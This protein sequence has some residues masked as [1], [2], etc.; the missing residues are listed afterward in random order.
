MFLRYCC[1]AKRGWETPPEQRRTRYENTNIRSRNR[2]HR[3]HEK[4]CGK[5]NR[6]LLRHDIVCIR[7][8][9]RCLRSH[10]PPRSQMES[11]ERWQHRHGRQ[12]GRIQLRNRNSRMQMGRHRRHTGNRKTTAPQGS[13][14]KR[15]LRNPR[16]RRSR[17][18][19]RK[20]APQPSQHYG[21][22]G[23]PTVQ[24][25]RGK[26][27]PSR[28]MVQENRTELRRA[29]EPHEA[30]DRIKHRKNMVRRKQP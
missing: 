13:E 10:R 12:R 30:Y 3:H 15:K 25:G 7:N 6:R 26:R 24:G 19:H 18:A 2:T 20:N 9:L 1:L 16:T 17:T 22:Q 8:I 11:D 23:R 21:K 14:S 4:R 28:K 27:K 29:D 5:G